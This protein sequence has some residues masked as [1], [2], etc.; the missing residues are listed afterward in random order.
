MLSVLLA[1]LVVLLA[2]GPFLLA[3]VLIARARRLRGLDDE[4]AE[5]VGR[6]HGTGR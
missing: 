6:S 5:L 3:A 2:A 4:L 1:L